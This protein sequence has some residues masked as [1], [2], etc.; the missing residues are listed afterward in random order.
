MSLALDGH[1][2][3]VHGLEE[4]GLRPWRGAVDLV[5]EQ[6][7]REDGAAVKREGALLRIEDQ[8]AGDVARQQI[9]REL[10]TGE[11]HAEHPGKRLGERR[12][13]HAGHVL[14]EHVPAGEDADQGEIDDGSLA[15][16]HVAQAG[17]ELLDE[18]VMGSQ[19]CSNIADFP[20]RVP[21]PP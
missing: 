9:G 15:A 7:V 17:A 1:L 2:G 19:V 5:G 11:S 18:L 4:R 8:R 20:G 13:A 12:L 10:H 21:L 16:E 14:Q 3:L 6:D